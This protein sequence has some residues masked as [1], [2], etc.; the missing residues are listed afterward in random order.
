[1]L[2]STVSQKDS[3]VN[4]MQQSTGHPIMRSVILGAAVH[5]PAGMGAPLVRPSEGHMDRLDKGPE[6]AGLGWVLPGLTDLSE[7]L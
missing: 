7:V 3:E 5:R 2:S 4:F 1:M 6:G